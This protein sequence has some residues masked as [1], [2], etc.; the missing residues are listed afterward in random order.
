[1]MKN[2]D[3]TYKN[4]S[5]L[6]IRN[7]NNKSY[8]IVDLENRT[9]QTID[10]GNAIA[11]KLDNYFHGKYL[12]I[13]RT[14]RRGSEHSGKMQIQI[15]DIEAGANKIIYDKMKHE[16]DWCIA[17]DRIVCVNASK[18]NVRATITDFSDKIIG[19]VTTTKILEEGH[20]STSVRLYG[21]I[22]LVVASNRAWFIDVKHSK[23]LCSLQLI[24]W[25]DYGKTYLHNMIGTGKFVMSSVIST[26]LI[27]FES[28]A[29]IKEFK[30]QIILPEHDFG[31][32]E[33]WKRPIAFHELMD[34]AREVI[35]DDTLTKYASV[36][37]SQDDEAN[38]RTSLIYLASKY[39]NQDV[40]NEPE[41]QKATELRASNKAMS[42]RAVNMVFLKFEYDATLVRAHIDFL[43]SPDKI[44]GRAIL[45]KE[46]FIHGE[47]IP[48]DF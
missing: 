45:Y 4:G 8:V 35:G 44:K 11:V 14:F 18:T 10:M 2:V 20:T 34:F 38:E 9:T 13:G 29:I 24:G 6:A 43:N 36:K 41:N 7:D 30:P 37:I 47:W 25:S 26:R 16:G 22:L 48:V 46:K 33:S 15:Y 5:M 39:F 23:L 21:D 31:V 32:V 19:K 42:H 3:S 12:A 28:I 40:N 27:D 1:M 17:D